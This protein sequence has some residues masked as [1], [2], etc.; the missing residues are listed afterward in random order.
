MQ[1]VAE[2]LVKVLQ[3]IYSTFPLGQGAPSVEQVL[4]VMCLARV[5]RIKIAAAV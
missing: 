5:S 2:A 1:V 3:H 4:H